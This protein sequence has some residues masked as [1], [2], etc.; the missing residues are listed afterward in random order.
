LVWTVPSC[1][2][3]LVFVRSVW[4]LLLFGAAL[5]VSVAGLVAVSIDVRRA[6]RQKS[7][8]IP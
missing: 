7:P 1:I 6:E 4:V 5:L 2:L 3:V 8:Y